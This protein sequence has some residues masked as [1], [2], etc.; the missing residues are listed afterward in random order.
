MDDRGE[1]A[2]LG[3]TE[4]WLRAL[5]FA[6]WTFVGVSRLAGHGSAAGPGFWP[7]WLAPWLVYGAAFALA[8]L[9]ARL[10]P[11]VRVALLAVQAGAVVALPWT[12]LE[13]FEG[14][15]LAIVV[16]Q[17]PTVLSF[18]H[19][20]FWA[21][22]QA[23]ALLA[24]VFPFKTPIELM[25]I[26]GAYSSFSFFALLVY[27]LH[28]QERR[29]RTE[30]AEANAALVATQALLIEGSRQ[31]ERLRIARELHDSLGHYLAALSLQL[32][33]AGQL[34]HGAAAEPVGRANTLS[35]EALAEVRRVVSAIQSPPGMDLV[36]SIRALAGS[37]PAPRVSVDGA[38]DLVID[39]AEVAHALFRCVQEAITNS[40]KHASADNVW[41]TV[42]GNA[43]DLRI[44]VRDD[45]RGVPVVVRGRGLEG[46][47]ARAVQ[48]GGRADFE[49][50]LGRGFQVHIVVPGVP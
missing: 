44:T 15:L 11:P 22:A 7:P 38:D 23:I 25:E 34:A 49:S 21:L 30:L 29:S 19:A 3:R 39:D 5:G 12:G 50:S 46:M 32:E 9:R 1:R 27:R 10:P 13:G 20:V 28:L 48:I 37:I 16:A 43:E 2:N 42:R 33:L 35:R 14:L 24:T 8:S 31:G 41:V 36:P 47:Q 4:P 40:I 17:A 6:I 45:G 26:L 18:R